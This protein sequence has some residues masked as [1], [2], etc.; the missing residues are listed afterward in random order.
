MNKPLILGISL[1]ALSA[2]HTPPKNDISAM[3]AGLTAAEATAFQY[4][5][6]PACSGSNGPGCSDPAISAKIKAADNA[7]YTALVTAQTV[8]DNVN[9]SSS[10]ISNAVSAA[11]TAL[12]GLQTVISSLPVTK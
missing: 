10:A 5:T 1:L 11:Q 7:A 2:C 8:A 12:G 3:Q 9:S 6:L 4:V